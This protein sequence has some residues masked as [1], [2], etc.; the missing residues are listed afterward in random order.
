MATEV[1]ATRSHVRETELAARRLLI[2]A[3][4]LEKRAQ[5]PRTD[6]GERASLTAQAG[7]LRR[8]ARALLAEISELSRRASAA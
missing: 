6:A 2:R 7:E 5:R 8:D 1:I 3:A 4:H